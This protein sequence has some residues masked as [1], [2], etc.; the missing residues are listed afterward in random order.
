MKRYKK[1][2]FMVIES[3]SQNALD[4]IEN[5]IEL[6]NTV[7]ELESFCNDFGYECIKTQGISN[8]FIE[9]NV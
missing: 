4:K 7:S 5:N 3:D 8:T 2:L 6:I 1:G 9:I